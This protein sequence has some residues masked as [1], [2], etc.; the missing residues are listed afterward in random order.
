VTGFIALDIV[1]DKIFQLRK[2]L[3]VTVV[4][5]AAKVVINRALCLLFLF[6]DGYLILRK[7]I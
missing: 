5:P 6:P 3:T 4:V 1:K 2:T 7:N